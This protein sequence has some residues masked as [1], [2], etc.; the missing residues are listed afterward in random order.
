MPTYVTEEEY[1]TIISKLTKVNDD[2]IHPLFYPLK[3][4]QFGTLLQEDPFRESTDIN[5]SFVFKDVAYVYDC[6]PFLSKR[7]DVQMQLEQFADE[8]DYN[9]NDIIMYDWENTGY[10]MGFIEHQDRTFVLFTTIYKCNVVE[11]IPVSSL[12]VTP[13]DYS[14]ITRIAHGYEDP[15]PQPPLH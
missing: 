3:R 4:G 13:S 12:Q 1:N 8:F 6:G 7:P 2:N 14:H 15:L 11:I 5:Q 9:L 10:R